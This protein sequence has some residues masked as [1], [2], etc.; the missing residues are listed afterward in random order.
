MLAVSC[1]PRLRRFMGLVGVSCSCTPASGK[2]ASA[3]VSKSFSAQPW[4]MSYNLQ[5]AGHPSRRPRF[6]VKSLEIP[7]R[8]R[9][10][11]SVWSQ[12]P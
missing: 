6:K 7:S 3:R 1:S 8:L 2:A 5:E 4:N 9:R 12:R 11:Y 10:T